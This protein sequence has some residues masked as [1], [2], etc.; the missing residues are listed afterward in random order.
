MACIVAS[1]YN[2][3]VMSTERFDLALP[4]SLKNGIAELGITDPRMVNNFIVLAISRQVSEALG[5]DYLKRRAARAD[6]EEFLRI[7][8][9]KGGEPPREG[10]ELPG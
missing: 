7:L 10:D 2:Q 8:N 9:R 5:T 3:L 4:T 1:E 6:R